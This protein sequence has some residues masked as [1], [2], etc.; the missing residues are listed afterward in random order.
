MEYG[1]HDTSASVQLSFVKE[2]HWLRDQLSAWLWGDVFVSVDQVAQRLSQ[3]SEPHRQSAGAKYVRVCCNTI[4]MWL[5]LWHCWFGGRKGTRPVKTYGGWWR[6][7]LVSPDGVAPSWMVGVSASGNLP[8]HHKVQKFSSS[9][10]SPGCFLKEGHKTVVVCG[11]SA[12]WILTFCCQ[13]LKVHVSPTV[14][15][16]CWNFTF[17]DKRWTVKIIRWIFYSGIKRKLHRFVFW[18]H[19]FL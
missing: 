9:T 17:C 11:G 12:C 8:L 7:A 16:I 14:Q 19:V 15:W 1:K 18:H 5:L 13:F 6:R 2:S 4:I 3:T 10:G